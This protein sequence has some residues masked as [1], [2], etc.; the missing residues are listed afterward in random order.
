MA[1]SR[2]GA[3]ERICAA[4]SRQTGFS[5]G[6]DGKKSVRRTETASDYCK[7]TG[8]PEILI[9]DDSASALD[10]ATDAALR[11]AIRDMEGDMTVFIVSQRASSIRYADQIIVLDDGEMA[12]IGTHDEL[13]SRCSVYQEIYYSQY[14]KAQEV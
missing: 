3:G 12:D 6:A 10:Y 1:G 5:C 7:G 2:D 9:L 14:P 8:G 13:L 4:E 11:Q